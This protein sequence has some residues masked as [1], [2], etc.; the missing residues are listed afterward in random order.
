MS[1]II[2]KKTYD[3]LIIFNTLE[4]KDIITLAKN[5]RNISK[6]PIVLLGNNTAE[7]SKI[8]DKEN[9]AVIDKIFTWNGDGK[10]ILTIVQTIEDE[11]NIAKDP[12]LVEQRRCILLI[13][14]SI[15][16]YSSYLLLIYEEVWKVVE[17]LMH[18]SVNEEHRAQR[19]KNR[20]LV[21]HAFN[22]KKGTELYEKYK[23]NLI[24]IITDNEEEHK[25]KGK[26]SRS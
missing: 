24:S 4:D 14:D 23:N 1:R 22:F 3:L 16:Y 2:K 21:L 10:I 12:S 26:T 17:N 25:E 8:T 18:D 20:P 5:I 19:L 7:L 9:R 6:I 11:E 13:E 15:Q